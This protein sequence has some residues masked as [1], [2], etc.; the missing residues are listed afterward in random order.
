MLEE[1]LNIYDIKI[2]DIT[3]NIKNINQVKI[4]VI[5]LISNTIRYNYINTI[6]KKMDL[7]YTFIIVDYPKEYICELIKSINRK[8]KK[9]NNG[10]IGCLLSH[11]WCLKKAINDNINKFIIF[12]DDIIFH[13]KFNE[14][15]YNITNNQK[16]DYLLLGASDYELKINTQNMNT[17]QNVYTPKTRVAGA[18]AIMYSIE[19]AK[20]VY[21]FKTKYMSSFDDGLI[22]IFKKFSKTSGVCYPNLICAE[23]STTNL[24]HEFTSFKNNNTEQIYYK[25][26]Y[27]NKF[28]FNDYHFIYLIL[29]EI[30]LS[31]KKTHT[32]KSY[33]HQ[34]IDMYFDTHICNGEEN[35]NNIKNSLKAK[36][37]YDFYT[38][39]DIRQIKGIK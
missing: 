19:G 16:Y 29:F 15:F 30:D 11:M 3:N 23:L 21:D 24:G 27:D 20:Y 5:N 35:T 22:R 8:T 33:V 36:L 38:L 34:L 32:Y 10:E 2:V 26:C 25:H 14:L 37:N 18:F 39:D 31:I 4:Y 9:L 13:K 7:N 28:N 1:I 12:E 17:E 6:M